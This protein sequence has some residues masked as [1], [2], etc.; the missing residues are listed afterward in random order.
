MSPVAT[1][2]EQVSAGAAPAPDLA[3]DVG[4]A[5][6]S[7]LVRV[8]LV[9]VAVAAA[10]P[11]SL[12]AL[13]GDFRYAGA[14]G[15]LVL[16]PVCALLLA[17]VAAWRHPWIAALR[18]GRADWAVAGAAVSCA[19]ALLTVGPVAA[20][21]LYYALR[22]DLLAVPL[23]AVAA[24]CLLLGVRALVGLVVPLL[25]STLTWPLP[26]RALL[27]PAAGAATALTSG[28]LQLVLQ[29]VPL[30]TEVD[31]PGDLRLAVA[32][33]SGTFEVVVASACSGLTGI[34]GTLLVGIAAQ[35]VLHG[36]ARA[37]VQWLSTAVALAWA[38]NLVRI[39]LLLAVGRLLGEQVALEVVHPVAGLLL[40]NASLAVL[41][42]AAPRFG[43]RLA[44]GSPVP[45]DTPLTDPAPVGQRLGRAGLVRRGAAL[46]VA[47]GVLGA[48][49]TVLPATSGAYDAADPAATAFSDSPVAPSGYVTG[50]AQP[51]AWSRVYY[52]PRSDWTRYR[53]TSTGQRSAPSIWVDSVTTDDWAALRAHPLL[54]CYRFHGFPLSRV[55]RSVLTA[56]V[57]ADEVVFRRPDGATW[58]VLSWQW[59][60]RP[61]GASQPMRHERVVL[62]AS[63]QR[64]DLAPAP[65]G[66]D[67]G[68][69]T[70][71]TGLRALLAARWGSAGSGT[72]PNPGLTAALRRAADDLV[73]TRLGSTR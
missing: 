41:L 37:R 27:E 45:A 48:L 59:P 51:Q 2:H 1:A 53:L 11:W 32:G 69:T 64:G 12:Q 19:A 35:Y 23:V 3:L 28:A 24:V 55:S 8:G 57:L 34:G 44:L 17:L 9:A 70:P 16:I 20:G 62:L 26:M 33:P 15:D 40:L 72:D 22:P 65:E 6:R 10:L 50:P 58:H 49:N 18:P 39:L 21:N 67:D 42:L 73:T 30:A 63:S 25:L 56:G 13:V 4:R 68:P 61:D 43:L 5:R 71:G 47:V 14:L 46:T 54:D 36:T 31:V 52:G 38:L 29:V 66:A 7:A 60:V